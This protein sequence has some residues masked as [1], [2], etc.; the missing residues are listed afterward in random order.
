VA[1]PCCGGCVRSIATVEDPRESTSQTHTLMK[2]KPEA[3]HVEVFAIVLAAF[4]LVLDLFVPP[5]IG[6]ADNG[7]YYRVSGQVGL[8]HASEVYADRYFDYLQLKYTHI[9]PKTFP[10]GFVTSEVVFAGLAL[11]VS[12]NV[13]RSAVFDLRTLGAVHLAAYVLALWLL[14][15]SLRPLGVRWQIVTSAVAVLLL[16][17]SRY[18]CYFNS[19]FSEPATSIFFVSTAALC[20][21]ITHKRLRPVIS[22]PLFMLSAILLTTSKPQYAPIG[23]M[24]AIWFLWQA[25]PRANGVLVALPLIIVSSWYYARTPEYLHQVVGYTVLFDEILA[26]S[27]TPNADLVFFDLDPDLIRY[28]NTSAFSPDAPINDPD[29]RRRFYG[30]FKLIDVVGFYATHPQRFWGLMKRCTPLAVAFHPF[31]GGY[32][33]DSGKPARTEPQGV[34]NRVRG[35]L[36]TSPVP[37]FGVLAMLMYLAITR[38]DPLLILLCS[39]SAVCFLVACLAQGTWDLSK[40]LHLSGLSF[41]MCL[42]LSIPALAHQLASTLRGR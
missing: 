42:S 5:I 22:W 11:F 9:E 4:I 40:N 37:L 38:R 15:F 8:D 1:C 29:F 28:T 17:D 16:T 39:I 13:L 6:L 23:V 31:V 33:P 12:D 14:M 25:R 10:P 36:P 20:L 21:L 34:W 19:F 30:H 24:L 2:I 35:R 41:N 18:T 27:P 32:T 7:D 26:N 3:F